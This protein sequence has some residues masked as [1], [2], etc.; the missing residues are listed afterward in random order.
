MES[1]QPPTIIQPRRH[2]PFEKPQVHP[3]SQEFV[4]LSSNLVGHSPSSFSVNVPPHLTPGQASLFRALFSLGEPTEQYP[5]SLSFDPLWAPSGTYMSTTSSAYRVY[6]P[7]NNVSSGSPFQHDDVP[8]ASVLPSHVAAAARDQPKDSYT[9]WDTQNNARYTDR[10]RE[11]HCSLP[12]DFH[13]SSQ[14]PIVSNSQPPQ[15]ETSSVFSENAQTTDYLVSAPQSSTGQVTDASYDVH[16]CNNF[17]PTSTLTLPS[18]DLVQCRPSM[19]SGYQSSQSPLTSG[20]DALFGLVDRQNTSR[21]ADS[22]GVVTLPQA[23]LPNP[24]WPPLSS[25][26]QNANDGGDGSL[27]SENAPKGVEQVMPITVTPNPNVKTNALSFVL[28]SYTQWLDLMVIDPRSVAHVIREGVIAQF[29]GSQAARTRVILL[30]NVFGALAKSPVL[31]PRVALFVTH[32]SSVAYRNISRFI[33]SKPAPLCKTDVTNA[34]KSMDLVMEVTQLHRFSGSLSAIVGLMEAASPVF[35]RACPE[36]P[37][38]LVNLPNVLL[39][40]SID[41]R[42]YAETDILTA[43]LLARRML[44]RYDIV[45]T[46]EINEQFMGSQAGLHWLQGIPD[47]LVILMA[48]INMLYDDFGTN[49][50]PLVISQIEME[51]ARITIVPSTSDNPSQTVRVFVVQECWRLVIISQI[52]M[53]SKSAGDWLCIYTFT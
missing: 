10:L 1:S 36:P 24:D 4:P 45:C 26:S 14:D 22:Q 48:W 3:E 12:G 44:L 13:V 41:L 37:G 5:N 40:P 11:P 29:S 20:H 2:D 7:S 15:A 43:T 30:S 35:R 53:E 47:K 9:E 38:Q 34:L 27:G 28:Q 42:Y 46:P 21:N 8:R 19:G 17:P 39:S 25:S 16:S 6:D 23:T 52:E 51:V 33:S 18:C 49:V 50:D 31:S 32:L